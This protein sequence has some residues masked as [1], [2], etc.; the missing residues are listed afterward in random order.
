[1]LTQYNNQGKLNFDWYVKQV[2]PT[3]HMQLLESPSPQ[4]QML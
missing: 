2:I 1:M 4:L 3:S